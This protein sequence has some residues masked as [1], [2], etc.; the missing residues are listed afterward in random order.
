[1]IQL[2]DIQQEINL[3][4]EQEP[5][6][7]TIEKLAMLYIVRDHSVK[8]SKS[9]SKF[10]EIAKSVPYDKLLEVID[11][12]MESIKTLYPNAY[13]ETLEELKKYTKKDLQ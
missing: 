1:M 13:E 9:T 5:C 3:L 6:F 4:E 2:D 7:S 10:T 11:S 12:H 8:Q